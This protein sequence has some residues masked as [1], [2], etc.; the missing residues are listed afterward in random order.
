MDWD[1][2]NESHYDWP[3]VANTKEYRAKVKSV[4]LKVLEDVELKP[5]KDWHND[6]WVL[7]MGIE[8]ER[9]HLET[10]AAIMRQV[11]LKMI[12]S[13]EEFVECP[14]VEPNISKIP[15]NKMVKVPAF[16]AKWE[17]STKHPRTYGWDN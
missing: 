10:S 1:D 11:P 6:L 8:H 4:I 13:V 9:I 14:K 3:S 16:K 15:A 17:R 12:K 5:I 7:L 2:L